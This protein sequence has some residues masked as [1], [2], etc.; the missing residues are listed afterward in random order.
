MTRKDKERIMNKFT[1]E[2]N[3]AKHLMA[4]VSDGLLDEGLEKDSYTLYKMVL[5]LEEFQTKYDE[6]RL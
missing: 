6:F 2:L 1:S 4:E 3:K 5:R